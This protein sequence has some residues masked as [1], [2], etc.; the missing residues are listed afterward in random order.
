MASSHSFWYLR[1]LLVARCCDICSG[2]CGCHTEA[3]EE[4]LIFLNWFILHDVAVYPSALA[5]GLNGI[6]SIFK[7]CRHRLTFSHFLFARGWIVRLHRRL[8][9]G[10]LVFSV[11]EKKE[12]VRDQTISGYLC[13][14]ES[15]SKHTVNYWTSFAPSQCSSV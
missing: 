9:Q 12:L 6:L 11:P 14:S 4:H 1:V 7:K 5:W 15:P 13:M 2:Y 3:G 8:I 10:N